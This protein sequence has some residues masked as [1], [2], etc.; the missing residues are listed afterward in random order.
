MNHLIRKIITY[1]TACH[2]FLKIIYLY[3]YIC[4]LYIFIYYVNDVFYVILIDIHIPIYF[5]YSRYNA[6]IGKQF[7]NIKIKISLNAFSANILTLSVDRT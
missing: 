1:L 3:I 5:S 2:K 7:N 4:I 6:W